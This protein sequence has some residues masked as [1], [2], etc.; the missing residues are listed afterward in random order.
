VKGLAGFA[1]IGTLGFSK[2]TVDKAGSFPGAFAY[3]STPLT[4][5]FD[6]TLQAII[7]RPVILGLGFRTTL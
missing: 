3:L 4:P 6:L 7:S 5:A 1:T 2:D